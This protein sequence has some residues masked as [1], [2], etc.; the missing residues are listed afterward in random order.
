[1]QIWKYPYSLA[2][3]AT[4][5][6]KLNS[7]CKTIFVRGI[8]F[9]IND[10]LNVICLKKSLLGRMFEKKKS[11]NLMKLFICTIKIIEIDLEYSHHIGNTYKE[12]T[13]NLKLHKTNNAFSIRNSVRQSDPISPVLLNAVLQEIFMKLNWDEKRV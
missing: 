8:F 3:L 13:A 9:Q 12:E 1:M 7:H 4:V 2:N 5:P 10:F 11:Y 6:V